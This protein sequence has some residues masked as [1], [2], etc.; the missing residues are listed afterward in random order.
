[1]IV[2]QGSCNGTGRM[3]LAGSED[4]DTA[5]RVTGTCPVCFGRFRLLGGATLPNHAART[6]IEPNAPNREPPRLEERVEETQ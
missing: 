1:M 5:G 2:P 3:P 4:F 6:R